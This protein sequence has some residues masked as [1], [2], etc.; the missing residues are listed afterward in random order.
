MAIRIVDPSR[1][2]PPDLRRWRK[3]QSQPDSSQIAF[4]VTG[5]VHFDLLVREK[6]DLITAAIKSQI[7]RTK[8]PRIPSEARILPSTPIQAASRI[9]WK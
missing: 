5:A 6:T 9:N 4:D 7:K 3:Q 8:T 1:Q 2:G